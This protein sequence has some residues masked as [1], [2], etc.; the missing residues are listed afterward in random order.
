[1]VNRSSHVSFSLDGSMQNGY[2]SLDRQENNKREIGTS[3]SSKQTNNQ[4]RIDRS[5]LIQSSDFSKA[6]ANHAEKNKER[7]YVKREQGQQRQ[8][9][10]Q[11]LAVTDVELRIK[12]NAMVRLSQVGLR[13]TDQQDTVNQTSTN[14][15]QSPVGEA[16]SNRL[17]ETGDPRSTNKPFVSLSPGTELNLNP[18]PRE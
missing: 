18:Q 16:P 12:D 8:N 13:V 6:S 4:T 15:E 11:K 1:M 10:D 17:H 3:T 2:E 5:R 7:I 14:T 9:S